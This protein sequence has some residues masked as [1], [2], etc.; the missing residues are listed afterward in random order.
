MFS[1]KNDF[2]SNL[3]PATSSLLIRYFLLC[4]A[5]LRGIM[6]RVVIKNKKPYF[7]MQITLSDGV[8][9]VGRPSK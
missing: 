4:T 5:K 6:V 9:L 2:K 7:M 1:K 3:N 8:P